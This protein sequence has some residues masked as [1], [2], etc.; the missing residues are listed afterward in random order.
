MKSEVKL[1]KTKSGLLQLAR[2]LDNTFVVCGYSALN[3]MTFVKL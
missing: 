1:I 2:H 3:T